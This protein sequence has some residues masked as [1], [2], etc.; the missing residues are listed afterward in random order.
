MLGEEAWPLF[1][2]GPV[3]HSRGSRFQLRCSR[4]RAARAQS[5]THAQLAFY[6]SNASGQLSPATDVTQ[7]DAYLRLHSNGA[8]ARDF[9]P[10]S[11]E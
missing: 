8:V 7:I 9:C 10:S 1:F 2:K 11:G 4:L 6:T 5:T 3:T